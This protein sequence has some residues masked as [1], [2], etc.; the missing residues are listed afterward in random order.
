LINA[1]RELE[2]AGGFDRLDPRQSLRLAEFVRVMADAFEDMIA[3][4]VE[5]RDRD[6]V[7]VLLELLGR[8]V[9]AELRAE[10]VATA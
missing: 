1:I 3:R 2:E 7:V 4:L 9:R 6:G 10:A 5:L 8:S